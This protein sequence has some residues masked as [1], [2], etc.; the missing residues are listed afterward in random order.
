MRANA[1]KGSPGRSRAIA[2]RGD[3][4]GESVAGRTCQHEKHCLNSTATGAVC[5]KIDL[6]AVA[7]STTTTTAAET[8]TTLTT[9]DVHLFPLENTVGLIELKPLATVRKDPEEVAAE[10]GAPGF[11]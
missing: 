1:E 2:K 8:T 10:H 7:S 4:E 6:N 9:N 3:R 5:N 11:G